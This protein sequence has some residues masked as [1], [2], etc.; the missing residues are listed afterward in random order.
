MNIE[1]KPIPDISVVIPV[2]NEAK[3]IAAC[4]DGI[5]SQTVPV[6]EIIIIDSGSTDG[7]QEIASNYSKVTVIEI[8]PEE[9]NHGD[10]RNLGVKSAKGEYVLFTVG[11]ARPVNDRWISYLLSGFES[12][13]V[14]GVCGMQVVAHEKDTNPVEWFKPSNKNPESISYQYNSIEEYEATSAEEKRV[15]C[16]WDDVSAMY[17]K[18]V[19]EEVPFRRIVYGED[20]YWAI[21]ALK[22][23]YILTYNPSAQVYHFHQ[24]DYKTTL[25]RTIAVCYLRYTALGSTPS[26]IQVPKTLFTSVYR[27]LKMSNLSLKEKYFWISYNFNLV[28][29]LALG[30]KLFENARTSGNREELDILHKKYCGSPPIPLKNHD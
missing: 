27:L 15:A 9:F 5:L 22:A 26:F 1:S 7:T 28:R 23:G 13:S 10:T 12:D 21:D 24:E 8:L 29:A 3:R 11:D 25:K 4:L 30:I 2:K 6:F 20:V 16:G 18:K 17:R 19:V 14:A